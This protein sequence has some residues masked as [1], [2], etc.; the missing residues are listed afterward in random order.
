MNNDD[1]DALITILIA[2]SLTCIVGAIGLTF[3]HA[4]PLEGLALGALMYTTLVV[5]GRGMQS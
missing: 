1:L 3:G 2:W 5:A 4:E